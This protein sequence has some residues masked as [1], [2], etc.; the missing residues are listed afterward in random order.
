[1]NNVLIPTINKERIINNYPLRTI[2]I[3]NKKTENSIIS[4]IND[5]PPSDNNVGS[6]NC[7]SKQKDDNIDINNLRITF[8]VPNPIKGS[9]GHRNIYRAVR[10]LRDRGHTI[11]VYYTETNL[12]PHKIKKRINDWY[13]DMHDVEYRKYTGVIEESD[14]AIATWWKTAYAVKNNLGKIRYPFYFVQDFE[15]SFY[16]VCSDYILAENTYRMGFSHICSGQW[17]SNFL[18]TKYGAESDYFQFPVNAS[19]YN[20]EKNKRTKINKNIIFFAKPEMDRRCYEIGIM[21]LKIVNK[22]RPDI[23]IILWGS[24]KVKATNIPF[25]VTIKGLLPSISDLANL[26][27]NADLGI[28]FSTTNPSLVPYEMLSCGCP[29]V[30]LDIEGAIYKYGGSEDRVF[31]F[32]PEPDKMAK[33]IIDAIDNDELLSHKAAEGKKWVNKEFPSEDE[34]G[35]MIHNMIINKITTGRLFH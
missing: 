29:V 18:Q 12:P 1:M 9:G 11:I 33:Q 24:N 4:P 19:V 20:T 21:A 23:E 10:Y 7:S 30:D 2:N 15:P 28:V 17:C 6:N 14:V 31:L 22:K 35:K 13:Y 3:F 34:M 8:V 26:Y 32:G 16:P 5:C 25:K 27:V